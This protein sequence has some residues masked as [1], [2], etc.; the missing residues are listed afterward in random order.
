LT[1]AATITATPQ[2]V[3]PFVRELDELVDRVG[4][5]PTGAVD[6]IRDVLVRLL[7]DELDPPERDCALR[8]LAHLPQRS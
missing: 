8:A 7:A 2:A 3:D 4:S 1:G 5:L 6:A